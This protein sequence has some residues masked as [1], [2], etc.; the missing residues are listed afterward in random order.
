MQCFQIF[1]LFS[2]HAPFDGIAYIVAT[3]VSVRTIQNFNGKW[4]GSRSVRS[5]LPLPVE[6]HLHVDDT[7]RQASEEARKQYNMACDNLDN[8]QQRFTNFGKSWIRSHKLHPDSFVQ[9][10]LQYAYYRTYG[11]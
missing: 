3:L 2:Q 7:L 8:R 5:D 1:F 4:T 10:A 11:R 9:V 6:H